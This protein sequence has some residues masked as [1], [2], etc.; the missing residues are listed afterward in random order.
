MGTDSLALV[1]F[2]EVDAMDMFGKVWIGRA[3][4]D[5]ADGSFVV[6]G[7]DDVVLNEC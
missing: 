5:V 2:A 3:E 1:S 6:E 4:L 7:E